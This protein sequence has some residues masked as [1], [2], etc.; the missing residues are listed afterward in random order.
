MA[1]PTITTPIVKSSSDFSGYT[2]SL[3]SPLRYVYIKTGCKLY[4]IMKSQNR[5]VIENQ[6]TFNKVDNDWKLNQV[7]YGFEG[8][9]KWYIYN[10]KV[11][12]YLY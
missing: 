8:E 3:E 7:K 5:A 6:F 10:I 1:S 12:I 4:F 2:G 9:D 11:R